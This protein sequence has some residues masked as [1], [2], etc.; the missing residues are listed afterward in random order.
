MRKEIIY[1]VQDSDYN[2]NDIAVVF[3][4]KQMSA[5]QQERWLNRVLLLVLGTGTLSQMDINQL[6]SELQSKGVQYIV[7]LAS[8]LKYDE[9]E[10]LYNELLECCSHVPNP[11]N[12]NMA[13][14]CNAGNIDGI[15]SDFRN[16]YKLRLEALKLNFGFLAGG[17]HSQTPQRKADI[18]F[19]KTM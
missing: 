19:K 6:Q 14:P 18:H 10:P 5:I 9:V 11:E 17:A 8:H 16:L 12:T 13:V 4:I 2:G 1:T 7:D 3:K 15:I